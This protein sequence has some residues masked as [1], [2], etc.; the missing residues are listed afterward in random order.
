MLNGIVYRMSGDAVVDVY[1]ASPLQQGMLFHWLEGSNVG[2]D[3]EQMVG[4][5]R[6]PIDPAVLARSWQRIADRHPILRTRFRW[7]GLAQPVQEVLEAVAVE[8][9]VED[10]RDTGPDRQDIRLD[11]FMAQDRRRGFDLHD[12][13]L[14]RLHLFRLGDSHFRL[15]FT[16]HHSLLDIS[17]IW[18]MEEVFQSYDA[19]L[20]GGEA[21]LE[22]RR[23]YK[24][25][26]LWLQDHLATNGPAAQ[27]YFRHLLE[28]FEQ[29]TQLTALQRATPPSDGE[30][31]YGSIR[32][33]LSEQLSRAIHDVTASCGVGA[34]VLVEAVWGLLLSAFSGSPD[35]IFGSTRGCRRSGLPGSDRTVGLFINTPPVRLIIDPMMT[36]SDLLRR[37]RQQSLEMRAHEHT[38]LTEIQ[39]AVN[40]RG[41]SLFDTIVV[42]NKLHQNTRLKAVG[43]A[44]AHRDFDFVRQTNFPLTLLAFT[45][46]QIH[47]TLSYDVRRFD[48]A[49]MQRVSDLLERLLEAAVA[50][51]EGL[52]GA[53]PRVPEREVQLLNAWNS[54]A[55]NY[56]RHVMIHELFE[57]QVDRTPEA[58]ALVFRSQTLSYRELDERA[59]RVAGQLRALGVGPDSMVGVFMDR[60]VEMMVALL[61]ILKA[62][63]AY[64]PMD[65]N[66]PPARITMMLEDSHADIVLTHD[67]LRDS[68]PTG[69]AH[70]FTIDELGHAPGQRA[71]VDGLRSDHLAYVIFTSGS[72]GRPKGVM[73]EHRNVVNFFT[74]MDEQ[75][76]FD[77]AQPPGVWL[78]VTSI[79]F[80]ISVLE[81]FWTLTRG[82]TLVLQEDE[83]R[84]ANERPHRVGRAR[85]PM[86]FS[87]F[88]FA[89]AAAESSANRYRLLLEGAKFA[90]ENGFAAVWTPERHFHE[91]GG[92]YPNAAV[93]SAAVAA[94][95]S[96]VGI[97]AGSVVLPLHNPIRCAEEWSVVDNLSGGR[98][99]LSFASGW[100]A[101]DFALAPENFTNRRQLMAEG[102][103]TV[104]AL[105]RG[106]S[107]PARSGDG[108]DISVR[109]FPPPVQESPQIW[110]TAGSTPDTFTMA[111]HIGASIL[112]NML[113]MNHNELVANV[114]SYRAS[115]R[116]SGHPGDGHVTLM[117][118][119]FV[120]QSID[121]VRSK[122]RGPFLS[123][124]R[125]STDLIN[126]VHWE[127]TGFAKPRAQRGTAKPGQDL[128]ELSEDE[129]AALMDHAFER[130]FKSAGLFGTADSCLETVD[131]L[132]DLGVDEIACLIDFGV[133]DE[134]VLAGL[135]HLDALRRASNSPAT[136]DSGP[137]NGAEHGDGGE[138]GDDF[139][140]IS[141]VSRHRVTHLQC[142]PSM[143]GVLASHPDGMAALSSVQKLLL[144][145]EALPPALV[146]RIRPEL[147]GELINMYGPTETTIWSTASPIKTA[148]PT[149]TIGRPIA[150]TQVFIVDPNLQPNPVGVPGELLIGGDGVVRGY[151]D[152]PELT[153]ERFVF[154]A[155]AQGRVYR[156][157][158]LARI[159]PDGEIEFSGR[160]DH[161][162]K[163]RGYRIELGE[164]EAAIGRHS[165][166][167]ENVVVASPDAL[168]DQR[169]VA[170]VVARLTDQGSST[171]AWEE[172][173]DKTYRASQE[174]DSADVTFDLAGWNDSYTGA[175]IPADEMHEWLDE[176]VGRIGR[177][178][179]RRVLEIGC[180]TGLL[181]TRLCADTER[182]VGIDQAATALE[183][184]EQQLR[185]RPMP[186]VALIH[187]AAHDV[188]SLLDETFDTI[189]I[190][191]V[192]QYFPDAG[193]LVD[194]ITTSLGLLE[195]G[196]ALF[197][198]DLRSLP[199][200]PAFAAS[201]EFARATPGTS[202]ANL[203][204]RV[205]QRVAQDEELV[206]DPALFM[207]LQSAVP[208]LDSV[209]ILLKAGQFDNELTR[210]R[211]DVV[212]RRRDG[213][214]NRPA[215]DVRTV[216][217]D[218]F[219]ADAVR[220]QLADRPDLLR[221]TGLA[222][223]RVIRQLEL[224]R[225]L[226]GTSAHSATVA[227]ARAAVASID[228]GMHPRNLPTIDDRYDVDPMWSPAGPDRFDLVFRLRERSPH[229]PTAFNPHPLPWP[230]YTNRP[231]GHAALNLA[232]KVRS[233]LR[234]ILPEYM[235]PSA[236]VVLDALPRTPNGKIDRNALPAPDRGRLEETAA[237]APENDFERK[238]AGVW[239]DLLSLDAVGV[240]T[241]LFDLGANS[242]MMVKASTL[243]AEALE[244]PLTLVEMFEFPTVRSLALH[245]A[246]NGAPDTASMQQS[247]DRA[248]TRKEAMQ[249]R[250]GLRQS[251][252]SDRTT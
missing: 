112:T 108:R 232:P 248:Q 8:L 24:D 252:R 210:F 77:P 69:V 37:L 211:Y 15:V 221:V 251:A 60:S 218:E 241:N 224:I 61:A 170:Y 167:A 227:D 13:P 99:G 48:D 168:G 239:Q 151:L 59:D 16:Y 38:P 250:R 231:S 22:E 73:V 54:T 202:L 89:A 98:V 28:G 237:I 163:I 122:V 47:F 178:S 155:G 143:A 91:F 147:R 207:A 70:V 129:M 84:L 81:L 117:L 234:A 87:L 213:S 128:S 204:G 187:A 136:D 66:Y 159:R 75:L 236:F 23:S 103:E 12:A 230:D 186:Q 223:D 5:L 19:S 145:G 126:Q 160:I 65:P 14:W 6:E 43:P 36:V 42:I 27:D 246:G 177:L 194:V 51:P 96:R 76:G 206:I 244:R 242:L 25:H 153:R 164:I 169:L 158:D 20:R 101:N 57:A 116:A 146:D 173:W 124:L 100:H 40:A 120:G 138:P 78:A 11:E 56:P 86:E 88:Y 68:V 161:Q 139:S 150:N 149:I 92:L 179:P 219:S 30:T 31:G 107:V 156:T 80:D 105:W 41:A 50:D 137:G 184:I 165:E 115:Y 118:H 189:I 217:L 18:V 238:I 113:V 180:G 148:S 95:T 33:T 135:R 17:V 215:A 183:R 166:I 235:V 93:T 3:V 175:P 119:T 49:A 208:E 131:R 247:H 144:G 201:V 104:R 240:E 191:S 82:F 125:T 97:R 176:I 228:P 229:L 222:H 111:G 214:A 193:Y 130:Y 185:I 199:L 140:L 152:Q 200:L 226:E 171:A 79:S 26:I 62:G 133:D 32:L 196:G 233:H 188:R 58:T 225:I 192:A 39:A 34:P 142:T 9:T 114:A 243:L 127:Q 63:G 121:E 123:Y 53:L 134:S 205:Q 74:A 209:E 198:G 35:V 141:Q 216:R 172:V 10:L 45:D 197:L 94:I 182:Y 67:R 64:V 85:G 109:M 46:T 249:R 203:A 220:A 1:P 190:N 4:D 245:L 212:L 2:V 106:E 174:A 52:V 7:D 72:T 162:V 44:F 181:L 83:T 157:G 21:T 71:S 102:I 55:R 90:D 154:L 110:I 29:Q 195:P 132:R